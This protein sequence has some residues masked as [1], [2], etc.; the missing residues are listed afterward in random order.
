[1]TGFAMKVGALAMF[2]ALGIREIWKTRNPRAVLDKFEEIEARAKA[3][4]D[5]QL[6]GE[7]H[8]NPKRPDNAFDLARVGFISDTVVVG[9]FMK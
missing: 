8:P 9:F 5:G 4:V 1:M 6:G 7:D 3:Y 2:D